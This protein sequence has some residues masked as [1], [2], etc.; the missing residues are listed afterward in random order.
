MGHSEKGFETLKAM[1]TKPED[2]GLAEIKWER[3]PVSIEVWVLCPTCKGGG[4]VGTVK[5]KVVP[6]HEVRGFVDSEAKTL[7][8]CPTCPREPW[9]RKGRTWYSEDHLAIEDGVR[10][11][12]GDPDVHR[13]LQAPY[14]MNGLVRKVMTLTREVGI[15]QWAKGTRFDSRFASRHGAGTGHRECELCAKAVPSG[16][17]VPVTGKGTDGVIH[18]AWVGEDCARKFFGVKNFKKEQVV[19]REGS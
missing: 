11:H 18:G 6:E 19:L 1:G 7:R 14:E 8:A 12:H 4:R 17:F 2:W 9:T 16:R 3:R 15:V 10:E 5:G 13:V